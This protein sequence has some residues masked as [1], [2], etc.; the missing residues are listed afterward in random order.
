M[1]GV[2]DCSEVDDIF[3]ENSDS[4]IDTLF[5]LDI[6]EPSG[7]IFCIEVEFGVEFIGSVERYYD[8]AEGR[9]VDDGPE[10]DNDEDP[11]VKG[12]EDKDGYGDGE[13]GDGEDGDGDGED[14]DGDGEDGDGDGEDKE[15]DW[16]N[17]D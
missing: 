7:L 12:S 2:I 4:P 14:G 6:G 15:G 9:D 5:S 13:D 10:G 1:D 8:G 17:E 11:L 16:E 3:E